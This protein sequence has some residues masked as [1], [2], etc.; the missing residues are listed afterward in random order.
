[1]SKK[2]KKE[3]KEENQNLV[4]NFE[5]RYI[6]PL[7]ENQRAS[8]EA[9]MSG[10]N[11]LLHGCA[12]SG[13][14]FCGLY[15]ALR[16][17][18][19][20]DSKAEKVIIVRSIVP[21]RD[22][23]FLPGTLAEKMAVYEMPYKAIVNELFCRGDAYDTLKSK[24]L[25]EFMSTSFIRGITISNAIIVVDECQN[26]NF[27]ELQSVI[28]RVG[29]NCRVIFSGDVEQQDTMKPN[30]I[31]GIDDFMDILEIMPSFA[32]VEFTSKDIL[33]SQFVK[34]YFEAK[35]KLHGS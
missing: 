34:E 10:K 35:E 19:S 15:L 30:E 7:T 11:L 17:I 1:M 28:T 12:A 24:G 21:T 26:Q 29:K 6:E 32:C 33:R 31:D 27:G 5:L 3:R 23:G 25:I 22:V 16:D 8:F 14:T 4:K 20:G 2:T 13:K 18:L 9:Y